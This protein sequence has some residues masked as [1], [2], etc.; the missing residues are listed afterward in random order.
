MEACARRRLQHPARW[1]RQRA[2]DAAPACAAAV[3]AP[4][5]RP[6][7]AAASPRASDGSIPS[8]I[9]VAQSAHL[10]QDSEIRD[11]QQMSGAEVEVRDL[12]GYDEACILLHVL[13][14]IGFS[15]GVIG[16]L[17][18]RF[19]IGRRKITPKS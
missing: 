12:P 4:L 9:L 10:A 17:E 19:A 13:G 5:R 1:Q 8:A 3:A 6:T 7:A 15:L 2:G 11:V 18:G 16:T 14:S